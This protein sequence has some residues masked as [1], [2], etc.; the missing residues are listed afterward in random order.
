MNVLTCLKKYEC[1]RL[2]CISAWQHTAV[3]SLISGGLN[4]LKY[5]YAICKCMCYHLGYDVTQFITRLPMCRRNNILP[6]P[7][8][9]KATAVSIT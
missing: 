4:V 6:P 5:V 3:V 9:M 1:R 2:S 7:S 8:L